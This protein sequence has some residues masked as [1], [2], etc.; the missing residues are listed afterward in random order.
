MIE[1]TCEF[2][3]NL[4]DKGKPVKK[5]Y[6]DNSGENKALKKRCESSDWKHGIEFKFTARNTP[7]QNAYSETSF[8]HL[9]NKG[10]AT[11]SQAQVPDEHRCL[12][13]AKASAFA[14]A[15]DGLTV[16]DVDGKKASRYVHWCGENPK[17]TKHMRKWG[18]AGT[19]TL[20]SKTTGKLSDRGKVCMFVGHADD[21]AGDVCEMW[22]VTTRRVHVTRDVIFL[23]K[24]H[25]ETKKPREIIVNQQNEDE[26]DDD[27]ADIQLPNDGLGEGDDVEERSMTIKMMTAM[28]KKLNA[29]RMKKIRT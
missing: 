29:V 3:Q 25:F 23:N 11:M 17:W 5:L 28:M 14:T 1:P 18:E 10:R 15:V 6:L 19:A 16:I 4:K 26:A 12:L 24:M 9:Y 20:K 21:H 7:Q 22:D 2:F 8:P 13:F 27:N